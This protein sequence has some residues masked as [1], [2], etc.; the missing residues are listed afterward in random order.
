V[1]AIARDLDD[2]L[3]H[4]IPAMVAAKFCVADDG[5]ATRGMCTFIIFCHK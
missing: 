1:A 3:I 4:R 5:A 2:I